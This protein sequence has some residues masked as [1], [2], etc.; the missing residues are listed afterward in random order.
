MDHV[1]PV[2]LAQIRSVVPE[3]FHTQQKVTDSAKSRTLRSSLHAV[4]VV[5]YL[6]KFWHLIG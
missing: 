4:K 6:A 1:F 3:I 2:N 5:H